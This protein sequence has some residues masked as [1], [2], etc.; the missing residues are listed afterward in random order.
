MPALTAS[1]SARVPGQGS[2][3]LRD[4]V[5][6][7]RHLPPLYE[8][9]FLCGKADEH[10]QLATSLLRV[11]RI[12]VERYHD[13]SWHRLAETLSRATGRDRVVLHQLSRRD[14]PGLDLKHFHEAERIHARLEALEP[15]SDARRRLLE[16]ELLWRSE[17]GE[18][19]RF[20]RALW[21]YRR[22]QAS[23]VGSNDPEDLLEAVSRA[24][25][26]GVL[27][28]PDQVEPRTRR[29]SE[30]ELRGALDRLSPQD[31]SRLLEGLLLHQ[32]IELRLPAGFWSQLRPYLIRLL[33][34][35]HL[36]CLEL[37]PDRTSLPA[38][39]AGRC[40]LVVLHADQVE[41]D[42]VSSW[43]ATLRQTPVPLVLL[44]R[45]ADAVELGLPLLKAGKRSGD[46][47]RRHVLGQSA[48]QAVLPLR[49][50][51]QQVERQYIL[52]V[53]GQQDGVKSR[54]CEC[55]GISRQTLYTKLAT[56]RRS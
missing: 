19:W 15:A 47:I 44:G 8:L 21:M 18:D 36:H 48:Q 31:W 37:V 14:P 51:V 46:W 39:D 29:F 54:A 12:S 30:Q 23:R 45:A 24:R 49:E 55:L 26:R 6:R 11:L 4:I 43:L 53:L 28:H 5:Q 35:R 42:L 22:S 38:L 1:R 41:D 20:S 10:P 2:G 25:Q 32:R 34:G 7:S 33:G 56:G 52:E 17:E 50:Y 13:G 16:Q 27:F 40:A 3:L 9:L